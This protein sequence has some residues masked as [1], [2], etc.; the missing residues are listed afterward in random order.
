MLWLLQ[1]LILIII[2]FLPRLPSVIIAGV[3]LGVRLLRIIQGRVVAGEIVNLTI[4]IVIVYTAG[5]KRQDLQRCQQRQTVLLL[6]GA[7]QA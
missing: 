2:A 5:S 7:L 3:L 4:L 6:G 1:N